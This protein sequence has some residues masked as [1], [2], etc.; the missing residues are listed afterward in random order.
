MSDHRCTHHGY[1]RFICPSRDKRRRA[2]VKISRCRRIDEVRVRSA[3]RHARKN[4]AFSC[5]HA[6]MSHIRHPSACVSALAARLLDAF[7][8][9]RP[10]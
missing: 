4:P 1:H 8:A 9:R 2:A 7:I 3:W 10:S 5:V 6:C